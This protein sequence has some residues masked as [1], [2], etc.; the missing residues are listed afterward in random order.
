MQMYLQKALDCQMETIKIIMLM[1][2]W[3][4]LTACQ[5]VY[6]YFIPR[7]LEIMFLFTFI[8]WL[9]LHIFDSYKQN[10]IQYK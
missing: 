10:L 9:F 3:M 7:N 6:R 2:D 8:K 1:I 5:V 4:I